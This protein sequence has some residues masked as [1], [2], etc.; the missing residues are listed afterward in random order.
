MAVS[1]AVLMLAGSAIQALGAIRQGNQAKAAA[2]FEAAQLRQQAQRDREITEL[3][4][5][6]FADEESRRRA[7][8]RARVGGSGVTL[9]GT[10]LAVLGDLAAEDAFQ[11]AIIRAGGETQATRAESK[12]NLRASEG[13]AARTGGFVRAG[14]SLL[15]GAA[16]FK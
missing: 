4:V 10:P 5:T 3:N 2:D 8:L 9:E 16:K 1:K 7:S 13:R 11:Q 14:A 12:A 15:S 6:Q